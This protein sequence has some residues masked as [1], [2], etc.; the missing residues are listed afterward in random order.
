MFIRKGTLTTEEKKL[1]EK[2]AE[3]TG[4]IL[5][6]VKFPVEFSC[7]PRW[8][9]GHHEFL[10]GGG[11]PDNLKAPDIC[12]EVRL[13]TIL[14]IYE[15]LT[16]EDRPYKKSFNAEKAFQILDNMVDQGKIDGK[17]LELFKASKAWK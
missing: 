7:V 2:H 9:A 4:R 14:D 1:V 6:E 5:N 8:A 15:A 13:L 17:I 12:R 3:V 11:Y 10:D 16:A